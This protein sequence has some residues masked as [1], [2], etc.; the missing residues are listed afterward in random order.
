MGKGDPG[1]QHQGGVRACGNALARSFALTRV[2]GFHRTGTEVDRISGEWLA[3]EVREIGVEPMR[4]EFSLSRVDPVDASLAVNGRKIE[5]L[6][7]F[8]GGFTGPA[9]VEGALG[10]LGSEASVAF[11]ELAPNAAEAGTLGE[12]TPTKSASG[13]CR[14][15]TWHASRLLPEQRRQLFASLRSA[16]A[17][18]HQRGGLI[19]GRV[20]GGKPRRFELTAH[21]ERTQAQAF[22]VVA[23]VSGTD[24]SARTPCRHDTAQRL[25]ELRE[26]ARWGSGLLARDHA[27]RARCE[28]GQGCPVCCFKRP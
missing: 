23:S 11:A 14:R 13:D 10:T 17:A 27:R 3:N 1:C 12:R 9:G 5:G 28:A 16:G 24:K 7:L 18:G 6:P 8:D 19:P 25:V 22:N 2:K 26:R 4:E 15:D 21:V 20:R